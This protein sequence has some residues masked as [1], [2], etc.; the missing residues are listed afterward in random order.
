[1]Q[2]K[3]TDAMPQADFSLVKDCKPAA[4]EI[5][6]RH[7]SGVI[8]KA[9]MSGTTLDDSSDS[10]TMADRQQQEPHENPQ[11]LIVK[12]DRLTFYQDLDAMLLERQPKKRTD[13]DDGG[14]MLNAKL[15]E[16]EERKQLPSLLVSFSYS[17][18]Y[19]FFY[20]L[21]QPNC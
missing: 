9:S 11:Q 6:S 4:L 1:M 14:I 5:P 2:S 21:K 12:E 13:T 3:L 8:I 16:I 18:L 17:S 7:G 10:D 15:H 19:I 20:S